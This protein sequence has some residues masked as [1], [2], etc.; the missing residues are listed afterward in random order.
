MFVAKRRRLERSGIHP[1]EL[2]WETEHGCNLMVLETSVFFAVV[3]GSINKGVFRDVTFAPQTMLNLVSKIRV[4]K[5]GFIK[6]TGDEVTG[7]FM[8]VTRVVRKEFERLSIVC[9]ETPDV[10]GEALLSVQLAATAV[11]NES[12]LRQS[13]LRH[14]SYTKIRASREKVPELPQIRSSDERACKPRCT[15]PIEAKAET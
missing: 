5:A 8:S 12:E 6:V 3:D 15:S 13:Q 14:V 4:G 9:V 10:L 7:M 2:M 11:V 1:D